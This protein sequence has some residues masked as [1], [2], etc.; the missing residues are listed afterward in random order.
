MDNPEY[1]SM[2]LLWKIAPDIADRL[3]RCLVAG[4][5]VIYEFDNT[6]TDEL[7][8]YLIFSEFLSDC[9][10]DT[11]EEYLDYPDVDSALDDF[12]DA[13]QG[14]EI[15]EVPERYEQFKILTNFVLYAEFYG[16]FDKYDHYDP[17][18]VDYY[19]NLIEFF[20]G[21]LGIPPED[22]DRIASLEFQEIKESVSKTKS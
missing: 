12:I 7:N 9:Y 15:L 20:A 17:K 4:S 8:H 13:A 1:R 3:T 18:N 22:R 19:R 16:E 11:P 2:N 10:T 5:Y 14:L 6:T 21:W